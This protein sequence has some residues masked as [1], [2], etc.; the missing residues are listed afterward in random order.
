VAEHIRSKVSSQR[1]LEL[2][3][4]IYIS[5][6]VC[7]VMNMTSNKRTLL[8]TQCLTSDDNYTN[9]SFGF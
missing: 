6:R 2:V 5:L 8:V 1:L 4:Y 7:I 3:P 9:K